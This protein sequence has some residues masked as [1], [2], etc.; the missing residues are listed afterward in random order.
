MKRIYLLT[1]AMIALAGSAF[2][3]ISTDLQLLHAVN[4]GN[5]I[6]IRSTGAPNSTFIYAFVNNGPSP[7]TA[8]DSI[9]L[10]TPYD[11]R[12]TL[13]LT[14]GI[15]VNDT[16]F[17][18]D[19]A[20]FTSGPASQMGY[21]WCDS[22]YV[23]GGPGRTFTD[24]TPANNKTCASVQIINQTTGIANVFSARRSSEVA[25]LNVYPNPATNAVNFK[26]NF[27][28]KV[29][30]AHVLVRDI[31]GRV[32]YQESFKNGQSGEK[33]FNVNTSTF[34]NGIYMIEFLSG[35]TRSVGKFSIQK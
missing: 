33:V 34:T 5:P 18:L 3:Q 12:I 8:A 24:P 16:V 13:I 9:I 17:Y 19:T 30:D 27:G 6:T 35:N 15:P 31:V 29:S 21:N 11:S 2:A 1:I 32:V 22:A 4:L 28:N 10:K 25:N 23:K 7:I 20:Q 26:Y 14:A